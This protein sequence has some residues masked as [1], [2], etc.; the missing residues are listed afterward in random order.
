MSSANR[1]PQD[2]QGWVAALRQRPEVRDCGVGPAGS[3]EVVPEPGWLA[4]RLQIPHTT[5]PDGRTLYHVSDAEPAYFYEDIFVQQAYLDP[6]LVLEPDDVVID[7]GANAGY[8]SL[9][10]TDRIPRCQILAFE[11]APRVFAAL[12]LNAIEHQLDVRLSQR[13]LSD[14]S[15]VASF[16][17]YEHNSGYS[18]LHPCEAEERQ[19]LE[20]VMTHTL[21]ERGGEALSLLPYLDEL[22]SYRL[23][24]TT[25]RV[26]V[27]T[28]AAAAERYGVHQID[29][30]KID[31]EKAEAEVVAGIPPELWPRIRQLVIEVHDVDGRVA[32]LS[33]QLQ[34]RGYTVV[35]RKETR[36]TDNIMRTIFA[37][38]DRVQGLPPGS[39]IAPSSRELPSDVFAAR[40][41]AQVLRAGG[42]GPSLPP[43][44]LVTRR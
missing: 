7:V 28:L 19:L 32:A 37:R 40:E 9:F 26:Q 41:L 42:L 18:T 44:R 39:R 34:A 21:Q 38:N 2:L 30:L 17:Y 27:E 16:C 36:H 24:S 6:L 25:M 12:C 35:V 33:E 20:A 29:L 13:A 4:G 15:G 23:S 14:H 1:D 8:F 22:L 11:P 31:A 3:L 10:V 5:L 43:I